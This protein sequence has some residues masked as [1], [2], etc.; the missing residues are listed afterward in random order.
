MSSFLVITFLIFGIA[1]TAY[2]PFHRAGI[3]WMNTL[4]KASFSPPCWLEATA[5]PLLYLLMSISVWLVWEKR[6]EQLVEKALSLFALQFLVNILWGP[7]VLSTQSLNLALFYICLLF[8]L[9]IMNTI[10]F[11]RVSEEAG[12]LLTPY[13]LWTAYLLCTTAVLFLNNIAR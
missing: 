7:V 6:Q 4:T 8:P 1:Y 10:V 3:E 5:W 11:L 12:L 9:T 13:V 2:L